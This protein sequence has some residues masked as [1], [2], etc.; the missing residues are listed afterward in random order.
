MKPV[1]SIKTKRPTHPITYWAYASLLLATPV[2]LFVFWLSGNSI[3][4]GSELATLVVNSFAVGV[5]LFLLLIT[6]PGRYEG[7]YSRNRSGEKPICKPATPPPPPPK[8]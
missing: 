1:A 6:Y 3:E 5:A 4:R 8:K 2:S 7:I